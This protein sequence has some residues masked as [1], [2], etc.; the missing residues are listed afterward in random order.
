[1]SLPDL[2]IIGPYP[3]W[4]ME[5]LE[6][7]FTIHRYWEASDQQRFIAERADKIRG[8]GTRGDRGADRALI[9]ALPNLEVI[10]CYGVGFDAIDI[11]CARERGIRVTNTPDVLTEDVADFGLAL[12]L[13]TARMIAQGDQH[14]RTGAWNKG[15]LPLATRL[16]GKRLG[17]VGMGRIGA[18]VAK[19]AA[20]FDM[21]ISYADLNRRDDLPYTHVDNVV[22]LARGSDFLIVTVAGG[23]GTAKIVN[24][25]VLEALGPSGM[26]INISR[27]STVDQAALLDAL[28]AR[29][30]GAAGLDVFEVEPLDEP[31]FL[32]LDNVV[33]QPHQASATL[34]TRKAMGQLV[35]DNL[36]AHFAGNPLLTPVV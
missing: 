7:D 10:S 27:G 9:E 20:A 36:T 32:A 15:P 25:E 28:E 21:Q 24:A 4:D 1:M 29:T 18:A 30:I 8:M 6:K 23:S 22:D 34:E 19:R 2:L 16:F 12:L 11:D 35:R 26:L 31:R 13:G 17:V 3:D 5:A 14:V 33:L